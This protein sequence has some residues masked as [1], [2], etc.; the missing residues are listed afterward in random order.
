MT[1][2]EQ[3]A[4]SN[5]QI[6]EFRLNGFIKVEDDLTPE[7]VTKIGDHCDFVSTGGAENIPA[8]SL[9][10]EPALR[11]T[12]K[13]TE[14]RVMATRKLFNM[15]VH[16]DLLWKHATNPKIVD[17]AADLLGTDDIKMYGDQYFMKSPRTGS[18]QPWH[19]DSASWRDIFPMDLVTAWT[20]IDDSTL[21]NGCLHF[22]PGTHRWGMMSKERLDNFI[23]DL[24]TAAWPSIPVPLRSGSISFHHSLTLHTSSANKSDKRRRG[25][26]IHFMRA[27]SW[28]DQTVTDAPKMPTFKQVRGQTFPGR[29]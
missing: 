23:E 19:Q 16:D 28:Q 29:V 5:E 27:N 1:E 18:A 20:A 2:S 4:L 14:N 22:V 12:A 26:A 25:Y 17:I 3:R 7:E 10:I 24:D 15:A 11:D 13:E 8:D 9:Q 21:E 6:S